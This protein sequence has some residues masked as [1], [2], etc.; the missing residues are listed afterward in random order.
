[1]KRG[2]AW[3]IDFI[4]SFVIFIAAVLIAF[5]MIT[6][7]IPRDDYAEVKRQA[8]DAASILA[9]EG[10]PV[11]WASG[12]VIRAGLTAEKR[13]SLRKAR[14]L[15]DLALNDLRQRLRITDRFYVHAMNATN[16]TEAV[17]GKCG[18]GDV[19]VG[20]T[21]DNRTLEAIAVAPGS[22]P[23]SDLLN[24]TVYE[25]DSAYGM[26]GR[27]DVLVLEGN[28]TNGSGLTAENIRRKVEGASFYGMTILVIGD[29]GVSMLGLRVNSSAADRLDVQGLEGQ[30]LGLE[31]DEQLNV[32][33]AIPTIETPN[34]K[35]F[36]A[37]ALTDAGKIAYG[38]WLYNDAK[39]WYIAED[40]GETASDED[41]QAVLANATKEMI[42]VDWPECQDMSVPASAK[43]VAVH[44]RT[45]MY[46]DEPYRLR[47]LVW[48]ER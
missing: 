24:I 22:H 35:D 15:P 26:L 18:F 46:H 10:Y 1:M 5:Q 14:E 17:F 41:L 36:T 43:Q 33:G 11:H 4:L 9:G 12:D 3:S 25:N 48:R 45:L 42:T 21:A 44:D 6:N 37:V 28:L 32:S 16:G 27:Q 29:P 19:S 2:Q 34:G 20:N 13:L 8:D 47:V 38:T 30:P 31:Q 39:V 23:F 7:V 40:D